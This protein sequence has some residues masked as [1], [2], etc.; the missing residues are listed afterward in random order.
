MNINDIIKEIESLN[1]I[2]LNN[3]VKEFEKKFNISINNFNNQN[4][5]I[6][7]NIKKN[8][9]EKNEF[10]VLLQEV[11]DKKISIIKIIREITNLG[12]REAKELVDKAP[13]II[14]EKLTKL[15]AEEIKKKLEN[16]GAKVILN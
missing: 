14:K 15:E 8:I 3:L 9:L 11:G 16:A 6:D 12:L 4:N 13:K 7:K 10:S 5:N 1:I 2:E